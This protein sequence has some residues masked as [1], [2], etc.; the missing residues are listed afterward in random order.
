MRKERY[1][2]P[3]IEE[4][5]DDITLWEQTQLVINGQLTEYGEKAYEQSKDWYYDEKSEEWILL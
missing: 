2:D 5:I 4:D 1:G 3:T